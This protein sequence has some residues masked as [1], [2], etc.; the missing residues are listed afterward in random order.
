[1]SWE[2]GE[3]GQLRVPREREIN[4]LMRRASTPGTEH[5]KYMRWNHIVRMLI[6][7]SPYIT[8]S[9]G[10]GDKIS[11]SPSPPIIILC[12]GAGVLFHLYFN[13]PSKCD[14]KAFAL[15]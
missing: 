12:Q 1:M 9:L 11:L 14:S 2:E 15:H 4:P 7:S 8:K 6:L 3:S 10:G 5:I 13:F